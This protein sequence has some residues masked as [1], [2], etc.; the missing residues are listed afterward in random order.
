[1]YFGLGEVR[2]TKLHFIPW[3]NL[4]RR[5]R[6]VRGFDFVDDVVGL[7]LGRFEEGLVAV[8]REIGARWCGLRQ[9]EA[10]RQHPGFERA[11]VR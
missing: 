1:M 5:G 10:A 6:A 2:G 4:H 11:P 8:V 9:A 7:H 3:E